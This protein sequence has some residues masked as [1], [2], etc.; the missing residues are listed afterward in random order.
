MWS[1]RIKQPGFNF[2][3]LIPLV[4]EHSGGAGG[5]CGGWAHKNMTLISS[6]IIHALGSERQQ[7]AANIYEAG[8]HKRSVGNCPLSLDAYPNCY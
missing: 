6:G 7:A 4:I 8:N 3:E 1:L 5:G 2:C